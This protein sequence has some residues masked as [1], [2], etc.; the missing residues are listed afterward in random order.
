MKYF[1]AIIMLS[2]MAFNTNATLISTTAGEYDVN[3][4]LCTFNDAACLDVLDDQVWWQNQSLAQEFST[5]LGSFF[6]SINPFP[7][8]NY[9]VYF[10]FDFGVASSVVA[11]CELA[12]GCHL[13]LTSSENPR[14]WA[15]ATASSTSTPAVPAPGSL[16]L[17]LLGALGICLNR[18]KSK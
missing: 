9:T 18:V 17:I 8:T 12:L 14:Y 5:V 7:S 2:F 6:G 10:A 16:L 13:N 15:V 4:Y 1:F 11:G 3:T